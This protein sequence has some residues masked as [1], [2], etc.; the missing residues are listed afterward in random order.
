LI[1]SRIKNVV[2]NESEINFM[3]ILIFLSGLGFELNAFYILE[4]PEVCIRLE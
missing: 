4:I 1:P 2:F 3:E